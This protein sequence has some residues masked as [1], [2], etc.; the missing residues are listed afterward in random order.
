[1][2]NASSAAA[3]LYAAVLTL[4]RPTSAREEAPVNC[5]KRSC[6]SAFSAVL[7]S[8]SSFNNSSLAV[9]KISKSSFFNEIIF[10]AAD[11]KLLALVY[12]LESSRRPA[13]RYKAKI[14]SSYLFKD[15]RTK[16]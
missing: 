1:M 8:P 4:S 11:C 12:L 3:A 14:S 7:K 9:C 10:S 5:N 15:E 2:A 13:S 6:S 16:S